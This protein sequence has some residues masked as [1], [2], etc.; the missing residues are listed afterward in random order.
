MCSQNISFV[1]NSAPPPPPYKKTLLENFNFFTSDLGISNAELLED[2][3]SLAEKKKLNQIIELIDCHEKYLTVNTIG[4]AGSGHHV[5]KI[6]K[7]YHEKLVFRTFWLYVHKC[8][9]HTYMQ[10]FKYKFL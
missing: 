7:D 3:Q 9:M 1:L 4:N 2:Y 5:T 8:L 10:F 6:M